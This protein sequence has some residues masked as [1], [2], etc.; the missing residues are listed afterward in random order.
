M[1]K[2][3]DG[4]PM[5]S[6][7]RRGGMRRFFGIMV[8]MIGSFWLA[9]KAGWIPS[10]HSHSAIFWPLVVIAAGLFLLFSSRH[11]HAD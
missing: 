5:K 11:K 1:A 10:E 7:G 6:E 3:T 4:V 9:H 2:E 8:A